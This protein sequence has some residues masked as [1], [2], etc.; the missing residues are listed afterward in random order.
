MEDVPCIKCSEIISAEEIRAF[1]EE[2]G[3]DCE[4]EMCEDCAEMETLP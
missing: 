3:F 4:P 1:Q 2:A